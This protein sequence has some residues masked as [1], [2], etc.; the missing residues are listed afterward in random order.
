MD[1]QCP[2]PQ[3]T[4]Q[5]WRDTATA[6]SP[7]HFDWSDENTVGIPRQLIHQI[8]RYDFSY[9]TGSYA[10]KMFLRGQRLVWIDMDGEGLCYK[11]R[12][13]E[14]IG[15]YDPNPHL[16]PCPLCKGEAYSGFEA[17]SAGDTVKFHIT[18]CECQLTFGNEYK[19]PLKRA[20]D[21]SSEVIKR[22]NTRA[23]DQ[24]TVNPV[25][26]EEI[27]FVASDESN[28]HDWSDLQFKPIWVDGFE[29][30][31]KWMRGK[32]Q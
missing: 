16:Q 24:R 4:D 1:K 3:I 25:T 26:D 10:G 9:P 15:E 13:Y 18:C 12:P 31:A 27:S 29:A 22:W 6:P 32:M 28:H 8:H 21:Y 17:R 20:I 2:I 23:D 30:G 11:S 14:E 7:L 5:L 19:F